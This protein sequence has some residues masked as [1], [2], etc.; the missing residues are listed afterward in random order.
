MTSNLWSSLLY[1]LN[2]FIKIDRLQETGKL[3]KDSLFKKLLSSQNFINSL[4]KNL[5]TEATY[6]PTINLM[7]IGDG[8]KI[9]DA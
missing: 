3:K 1:W 6:L 4:M 8:A 7:K 5:V 9:W 2:Q